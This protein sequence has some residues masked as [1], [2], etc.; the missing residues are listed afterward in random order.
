VPTL[1]VRQLAGK[2]GLGTS[3]VPV[4]GKSIQVDV[5]TKITPTDHQR[6]IA[7]IQTRLDESTKMRNQ[8]LDTFKRIDRE[9][10]SWL[11]RDQDDRKRQRDNDRGFGVK[12]VDEKLSMMFAQLDEALTYLLT[13][14]APDEAIYSAIA[15]RE[16]QPVA[17]GLA[18]LMN[19]HAEAFHHYRN[20]SMFLLNALKYNFASFG[21]DWMEVRGNKIQ[22]RTQQGPQVKQNVLIQAGNEVIAFD[23]YNT[24]L[25]PSVPP[26]DVPEKGEYFAI[27]DRITEFR[28]KMM[29]AN[30]DIYNVTPFTRNTQPSAHWYESHPLVRTENTEG[31]NETDWVQILSAQ[32]AG[33]GNATRGF[34]ISV[35]HFWLIPKEFGLSNSEKYEIWRI[36][37][38]GRNHILRAKMMENAHAKLPINVA[39]PFEDH[40]TWQTKGAGERLIPYQRFASFVTN[41]HQR[42]TRKKLYGLT[43]YDKNVVNLDDQ[44]D[45]DMAGGKIPATTQGQDVDLRRKIV[46]F[47]DGPDT[48]RTLEN[49]EIMSNIMQGILPT[50]MQQQ[51]AGLDRATQY[52]A[53][54]V[55]QSAN[56]RNLKIA[57]TITSQAMDRGRNMQLDN[58]MQFQDIVEILDDSGQIIQ[59]DPAEFVETNIKF[60]VA[61]G[62]KGLDRLSLVI[63]MKDILNNI[64]QSREAANQIDVVRVINYMTTLWGDHT[65]FSQFRIQSPV[66]TLS[67]EERNIA[68]QLLQ[69]A[70]AQSQEQ[71]GGQSGGNNVVNL[72]G[73]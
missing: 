52:Q 68:F 37:L 43:I 7:H 67:V 55:V 30:G 31:T 65:D 58:I 54:A 41:T 46:Q 3:N 50:N 42:A 71:D 8:Y 27:V 45:V 18:A 69:Q 62:L 16:Q 26:V 73:G 32:S 15:P 34:E 4:S 47:T 33:K 17:D 66:D 28:L 10:Y 49:V 70:V 60:T 72:P 22:K 9:Y 25:D 23:P 38:G 11:R 5:G 51:V 13:V 20:F 6:L 12:P 1:S 63:N 57:K 61:D 39:M 48:T 64:L 19:N 59:I 44:E 14:L 21:V 53:A 36:V 35:G 2:A 56:R 29:E 40:F 24:L